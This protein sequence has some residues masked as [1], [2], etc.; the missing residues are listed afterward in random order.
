MNDKILK[1]EEEINRQKDLCIKYSK[2]RWYNSGITTLG[3]LEDEL[4]ILKI[5]YQLTK[6]L[7][8]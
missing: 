7:N 3:R 8:N 4:K 2:T 6:K 5:E 1:K